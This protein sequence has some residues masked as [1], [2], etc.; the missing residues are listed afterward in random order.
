MEKPAEVK[1]EILRYR[2]GQIKRFEDTVVTEHPVTI[3]INQ[4]EFA[5]MVCTPEYVEDMAVGF[6]ASEGVIQRYDDIEDIWVQEKEG[7]VH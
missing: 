1:R 2:D 6:L 4:Q 7:F 3:K 5:T